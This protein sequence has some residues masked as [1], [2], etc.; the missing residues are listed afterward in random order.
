MIKKSTQI[1]SISGAIKIGKI[2]VSI[3]LISICIAIIGM[4]LLNLDTDYMGLKSI[5]IGITTMFFIIFVGP[6]FGIYALISMRR[7]A[8]LFNTSYKG[9]YWGMASIAIA[10]LTIIA[11][12]IDAFFQ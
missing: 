3:Q 1:Q 5:G 11:I 10:F 4:I 6:I 7:D 12:T 8:K 2:G 9:R